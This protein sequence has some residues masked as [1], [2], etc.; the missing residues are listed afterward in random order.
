MLLGQILMQTIVL[1]I[2]TWVIATDSALSTV[3]H[4]VPHGVTSSA[5]KP[6]SHC[7]A[8]APNN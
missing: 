5:K 7:Y 6:V 2:I 1:H 4:V 8:S 3:I